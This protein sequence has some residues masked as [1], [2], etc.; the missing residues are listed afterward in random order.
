M[1]KM[2]MLM[3]KIVFFLSVLI[4]FSSIYDIFSFLSSS[5]VF[6]SQSQIPA[7]SRLLSLG[8][9]VL[10]AA[11]LPTQ[12]VTSKAIA[13]RGEIRASQKEFGNKNYK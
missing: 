9:D 6:L 12:G 5:S 8:L 7:P 4:F 1:K 10:G 13:V 3:M 2:G 11:V